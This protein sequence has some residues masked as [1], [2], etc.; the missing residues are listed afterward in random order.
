MPSIQAM[1]L[2]RPKNW[3]DFEA[4]VGDA[5]AQRW[6]SPDLQKNGRSGQKQNGVDIYGPDELGRRVGIQCKRYKGALTLQVVNKEIAAAETFGSRLTTLYIATTSDYDSKLQREVRLLSDKRVAKDK[7]AVSLI[8]WDDVVSA[9]LLNPAVFQAHYPQISSPTTGAPD[10]ERQLAALELGY[11]GAALWQYVILVYGE[12]GQMAGTDPDELIATIR[13]LERRA[14]QLLAPEDARPIVT[15][16]IRVRKGCLAK[17]STKSDWDPVEV[18]AKRVQTRVAKS[19][20]LLQEPEA[21]V[22]ELASQLGRIYLNVDDLPSRET[23]V[24][25]EAKVR[26]ILPASSRTAIRKKFAAAGRTSSGYAWAL[27]IYNL[28]DHELRWT[29]S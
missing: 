9:L 8:F 12:Y 23:R 16:L 17:K 13:T 25:V 1:E 22:L 14:S 26:G 24:E 6:K 3:Q 4:I 19:S 21:K 2:P 11:Y 15:S 7:F 28:L 20:S 5:M 29:K 27:R 10:R 18:H